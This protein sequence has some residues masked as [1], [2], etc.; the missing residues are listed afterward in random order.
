M[1]Q[2]SHLVVGLLPGELRDPLV[3]SELGLYDDVLEVEVKVPV[4][5]SDLEIVASS[6]HWRDSAPLVLVLPPRKLEP[7]CCGLM[8]EQEHHSWLSILLPS[9]VEGTGSWI[10]LE[11]AARSIA[12]LAR[13]VHG[14]SLAIVLVFEFPVRIF[15]FV[16]APVLS[17]FRDL[18]LGNIWIVELVPIWLLGKVLD[19]ISAD[20]LSVILDLFLL[21]FLNRSSWDF[22]LFVIQI[23][24]LNILFWSAKGWFTEDRLSVISRL[25]VRL[26]KEMLRIILWYFVWFTKEML[27]FVGLLNRQ[28]LFSGH[29]SQQG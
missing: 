4:R 22:V 24:F 13:W 6:G 19:V 1:G 17:L 2:T 3:V 7:S 21:R 27:G 15:E 26:S 25:F 28:E 23:F 12:M 18:E 5:V 29:K 20:F 11:L 9:D 10:A 14:E 8:A 16:V